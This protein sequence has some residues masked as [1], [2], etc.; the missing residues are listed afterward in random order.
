LPRTAGFPAAVSFVPKY[1]CETTHCSFILL[2][3]IDGFIQNTVNFST[4]LS[5][6]Y[7]N[8]DIWLKGGIAP[9]FSTLILNGD[10]ISFVAH[11]LYPRKNILQYPLDRKL[12]GLQSWCGH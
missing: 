6:L 12:T 11:L 7:E 3:L 9:L 8:H 5:Q 1:Y 4:I 2:T 10:E